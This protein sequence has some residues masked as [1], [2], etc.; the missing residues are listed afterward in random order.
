MIRKI[1]EIIIATSNNILD[2]KIIEL[3]KSSKVKHFTGSEL[4]VLERVVQAN[5]SA[6]ADLVVEICGDFIPV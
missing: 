1:D 5:K 3:A 2:K 4:D 6:E